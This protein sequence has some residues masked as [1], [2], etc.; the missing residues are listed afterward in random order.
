MKRALLALALFV[1]AG[2]SAAIDSLK[3]LV[4]A[5][6]GGGWDQTAR[7]L[8]Q[9]LQKAG[10]VK[11]VQVDNRGGGG[12]T[13]GLAQFVNSAK[14]DGNQL[15]VSG[16]VM[17][18]AIELNKSPVNLSQVTP[19]ARLTAEYEMIVVPASSKI[20]KLD[21]LIAQFKSNPGGV[22]WGGGSAGGIDHILVGLIAK[23]VGV[24]GA[25]INYIPYSGGGE[26]NTAILGGHVTAGVSGFGEM[27][28]HV[29]NKRLRALAVSSEKRLADAPDIPTLKEQGVD[30]AVFNWRGV[31]G[32]PGI[33]NAQR[34]ELIKTIAAAVKSPQWQETLKKLD[35]SD[36]FLPGDQFKT[37]VE[38]ESKRV[39]QVIQEIGLAK[40]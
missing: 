34:E 15:L 39:A 2:P 8:A 22:S 33:S 32:A 17:V 25:K 20:Q 24:E 30:V 12:G 40:K 14:G 6:P 31:F 5:N 4:P 28:Q 7:N 13:I 11:T 19:I 23:A 38:A 3:I 21:D 10:I 9:A 16:L 27:I 35:W 26:A 36:A 18:G 37:Y 29:K 1:V